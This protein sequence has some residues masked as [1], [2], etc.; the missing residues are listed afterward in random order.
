LTVAQA[1]PK[2]QISPIN[3]PCTSTT[4]FTTISELLVNISVP[5]ALLKSKLSNYHKNSN[6][7]FYT[8]YHPFAVELPCQS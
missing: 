2:K 6:D 7:L 3:Q 5:Q 8:L 1:K 4:A